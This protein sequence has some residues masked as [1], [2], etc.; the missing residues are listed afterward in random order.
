MPQCQKLSAP[1]VLFKKLFLK[2]Y[3]LIANILILFS[4]FQ[5]KDYQLASFL[6]EEDFLVSGT[7]PRQAAGGYLGVPWPGYQ[8]QS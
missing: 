2:G 4:F 7:G 8:S 1:E 6:L 3:L 5:S